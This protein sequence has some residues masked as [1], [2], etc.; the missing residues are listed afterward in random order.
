MRACVA[1]LIRNR[2]F[3]GLVSDEFRYFNESDCAFA[4]SSVSFNI[5]IMSSSSTEHP[6][7]TTSAIG[8]H[9]VFV[10]LTASRCP[11]FTIVRCVFRVVIAFVLSRP[12]LR[13]V[14]NQRGYA[15][16]LSWTFFVVEL[17]QLQEG[18]LFLLL[19]RSFPDRKTMT[20]FKGL[21]VAQS[22][23]KRVQAI[24]CRLAGKEQQKVCTSSLQPT[25]QFIEFIVWQVLRW[26]SGYGSVE[27]YAAIDWSRGHGLLEMACGAP[28][29]WPPFDFLF[30]HFRRHA[31]VDACAVTFRHGFGQISNAR[32]HKALTS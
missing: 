6:S 25:L 31:S 21:C 24:N 27:W 8:L 11:S 1:A 7:T 13:K 10:T 19:P 29:K 32:P 9:I 18:A 5:S 22:I 20:V 16:S 12:E 17:T 14:P 2:S 4:F 26:R 15:P 30:F 3:T 28:E 23:T